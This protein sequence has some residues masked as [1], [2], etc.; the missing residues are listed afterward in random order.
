MGLV[1]CIGRKSLQWDKE[2]L[3]LWQDERWRVAAGSFTWWLANE[4][5]SGTRYIPNFEQWLRDQEVQGYL[6]TCKQWETLRAW[7]GKIPQSV[8]GGV[9]KLARQFV[10]EFLAQKDK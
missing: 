8:M 9:G 1:E 5:I 10:A 4:V 7:N 2:H 6:L 3:L